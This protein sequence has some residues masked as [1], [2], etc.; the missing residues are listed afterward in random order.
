L[1]FFHN[2][3]QRGALGDGI[4]DASVYAYNRKI[5]P[6]CR[7]ALGAEGT[8]MNLEV[9]KLLRTA[10]LFSMFIAVGGCGGGTNPSKQIQA[11]P[12][13][14]WA[15]SQSSISGERYDLSRDEQRGGHTL[16]KHVGQTDDE[17]AQRLEHERHISAASSWTNR[18]V[19]EETV[20]AALRA[21]RSRIQSWQARGYPRPNLA[22]HFDAGKVIG[23]SM[24]R[25]DTRASPCMEAVIVLKADGP[26]GFYVLTT[27]PE[28]R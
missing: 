2:G 1:W 11:P 24:R 15:A 18:E 19:A 22:L 10:L 25:G 23:Q 27:Y 6:P 9:R 26:T 14:S 13:E 20:G 7:Y 21:E 5:N 12:D 4:R 8:G 17:L 3:P 28:A 16:G